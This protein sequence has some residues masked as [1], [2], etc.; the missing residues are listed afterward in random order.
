M[1]Q[2]YACCLGNPFAI[3]HLI[4]I[5]GISILKGCILGTV[6]NIVNTFSWI[7][8]GKLNNCTFLKI[9]TDSS[10]PWS[11]A[12]YL[13]A[14]LFRST[15]SAHLESSWLFIRKEGTEDLAVYFQQ[16]PIQFSST[17]WMDEITL[18]L[19]SGWMRLHFG[20]IGELLGCCHSYENYFLWKRKEKY[21]WSNIDMFYVLKCLKQRMNRHIWVSLSD[22]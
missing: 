16:S 1:L 7:V 2:F 8:T 14:C 19:L 10:K 17:E 15:R 18:H 22:W 6:Y 13:R 21:H 20:K 5:F 4:K 11:L 3:L 9:F 12:Q